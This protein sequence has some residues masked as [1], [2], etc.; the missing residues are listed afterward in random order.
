MSTLTDS[1]ES[2]LRDIHAT[3]SASPQITAVLGDPPRAYDEVPEAPTYPYLSYGA[4]RSEDRSGDGESMRISHQISLHIWSRYSGRAETLDLMGRVQTVL[5]DGL[6]HAV[7]PLYADVF[8][9]G[10]GGQLT[11]NTRHGLLR[12]SIITETNP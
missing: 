1:A 10:R 11:P 12:L 9:A 3:L 8:A 7:V 2:L 4:I 5:E 6:P